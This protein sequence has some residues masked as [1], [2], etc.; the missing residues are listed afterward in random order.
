[1][2]SRLY[3]FPIWRKKVKEEKI[4]PMSTFDDVVELDQEPI[5][6]SQ[7]V[8]DMYEENKK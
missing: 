2:K 7:I 1:M 3:I 5:E 4:I 8:K 6:T